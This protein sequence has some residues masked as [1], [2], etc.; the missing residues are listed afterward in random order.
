MA[1]ILRIIHVN[2]LP[3]RKKQRDCTEDELAFKLY[4]KENQFEV[5]GI[6]NHTIMNPIPK[7]AHNWQQ[8]EACGREIGTG[9]KRVDGIGSRGDLSIHTHCCCLA[10]N[11]THLRVGERER[12]G[13]EGATERVVINA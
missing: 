3:Y 10:L 6:F 2:I 13:S 11:L 7:L 1:Q 12:D 8:R 9:H 5:K 4:K